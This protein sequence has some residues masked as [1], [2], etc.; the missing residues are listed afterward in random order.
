LVT[1]FEKAKDRT[2]QQVL[3]DRPAEALSKFRSPS[4][5]PFDPRLTVEV[6][7]LRNQLLSMLAG[8]TRLSLE[9]S[10]VNSAS[11]TETERAVLKPLLAHIDKT[12]MDQAEI[13]RA[14]LESLEDVNGR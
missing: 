8:S 11:W 7:R 3:L 5:P 2:A 13:S 4:A 10:G 1:L 6:N 14:V 12:S 9:L